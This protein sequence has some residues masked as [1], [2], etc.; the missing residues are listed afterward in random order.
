MCAV[1]LL[2]RPLCPLC[3]LR[4]LRPLRGCSAR[5][6]ARGVLRK[7]LC[8]LLARSLEE[9]SS[10]EERSLTEEHSLSEAA[11]QLAAQAVVGG[12]LRLPAFPSNEP[13]VPAFL[14]DP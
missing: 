4:P 14:I 1:L 6:A 13:F 10:T 2:E 9:R 8:G 3:P 5:G 12:Q 11:H 7:G